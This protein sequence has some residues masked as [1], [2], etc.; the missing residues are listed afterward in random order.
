LNAARLCNARH[1]M[2]AKFGAT[3][4]RRDSVIP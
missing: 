3:R 2:D 1:L 4:Q